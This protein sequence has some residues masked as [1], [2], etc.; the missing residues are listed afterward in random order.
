MYGFQHVLYKANTM[1]VRLYT[2]LLYLVMQNLK[3]K[4]SR[5][6]GGGGVVCQP[7]C[8]GGV[9]CQPACGR[10]G[11]GVVCQHVVEGGRC[12]IHNTAPFTGRLNTE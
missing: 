3:V 8:G 6:E 4:G 7:A 1:T 12:S 10:G 9:A 11:G 5:G 2:I